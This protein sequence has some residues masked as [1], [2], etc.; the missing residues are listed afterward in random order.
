MKELYGNIAR[1]DLTSKTV[2]YEKSKDFYKWLGGRGFGVKTVFEEIPKDVNPFSAENKIVIAAGCFTGTSI[3]G[4]SRINII[5][6]NVF[7]NGI[8]YSSGGGDFAPALRKSGIDALIIEGSSDKPVYLEVKDGLVNIRDA[9]RIWGKTITDTE[10]AIK[11]ELNDNHVKIAAIGPAGENLVRMACVIMDRAHA[12][13][14][15]G[16]GAILGSKKLKAIAA[17]SNGPRKIEV[18]DK[19]R[20][21]DELKRYKWVLSA[22]IPAANLK[23]VGTHGTAGAGGLTGKAPTSVRNSLDEYWDPDKNSK[24]TESAYKKYEIGRSTCYNCAIACLH[25]YEMEYDGETVKGIG[26]HANSVRA[27]SSNWDVDDPAAVFK[28]HVLCN[29][30]GLDVDGTSAT[31]AWAIECYEEGIITD[32]DTHGRKLTWGNHKEL[33]KLITDVA[34]REK[35]GDVLAE[36]VVNAARIIGRDSIKHAMQVKG[37]GI[38]EQSLRTHKAW[39]LGI[40]ISTRGSGHVSA[41]PQTEKRGIAPETGEWLFG[42]PEAGD[43][44]SYRGKGKLVGWYEIYKAL[45]DSVGICYFNAGWYEFALSDVTYFRELYN[46]ITGTE[47]SNE[48]LWR[49][50]EEVVNMEKAINTVFAGFTRKDDYLPERVM[51]IP[52]SGGKFKGEIMHRDKYDEMLE[53]YYEFHG[54]DRKTGLQDIGR[55]EEKGFERIAKFLVSN[56]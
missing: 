34:Y 24:V 5:S 7:N 21:T 50:G 3:P 28:A 42:N 30:Y 47:L 56:L 1:V 40:A 37:V 23:R 48:E 36:G 12:A 39:A 19:K 49:I 53:E 27:F 4:S 55:L 41:S 17:Y 26:M 16:C 6:K 13:A 8:S 52:I 20:F 11:E 10:L 2:K 29:E 22:S 43:P 54:W 33:I 31:I 38:N 45:V 44:V 35:F 15:G 9:G 14:W 25:E 51:T 46:S 32:E 18:F